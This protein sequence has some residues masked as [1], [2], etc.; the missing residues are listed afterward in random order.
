MSCGRHAAAEPA[1]L[2]QRRRDLRCAPCY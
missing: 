1:A 2:R